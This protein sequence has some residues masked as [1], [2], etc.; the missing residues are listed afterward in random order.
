MDFFV[1]QGTRK[2]V[3]QG[4]LLQCVVSYAMTSNA[5]RRKKP[6]FIPIEISWTVY[7]V[8]DMDFS[9]SSLR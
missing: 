7:Y 6:Q 5:A 8:F 1:W 2:R 3:P 4:D 9:S